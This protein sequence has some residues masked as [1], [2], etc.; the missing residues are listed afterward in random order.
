MG[1]AVEMLL[2]GASV[3]S[4]LMLALWLLQRRTGNGG[5]VDVGWAAGM[6]ILALLCAARSEAPVPRTTQAA[7]MA[8]VW[9]ADRGTGADLKGRCIQAVSANHQR[10]YPMVSGR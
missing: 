7:G 2:Y 1:A 9:G 3:V 10:L 5:I 4:G 8:A 6:V